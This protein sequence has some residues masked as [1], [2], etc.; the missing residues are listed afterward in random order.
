MHPAEQLAMDGTLSGYDEAAQK[1]AATDTARTHRICGY[2]VSTGS[3]EDN[4]LLI[5]DA[6]R[7]RRGKWVVTLNT[8]MIARGVREPEYAALL[9]D[10]DLIFA[11]GMPIVWASRGHDDRNSIAERTTGV[12]LVQRLFQQQEIPA[13]AIIGGQNPTLTLERFPA[14]RSACKWV[15]SGRVDNSLEQ[16]DQFAATL[17][18]QEVVIVFLAL[19][20]PKQDHLAK[21]LR[22][23]L[24]HCVVIGVGGT[25]EILGPEGSRAPNWMQRGGLEWL[26]RLMNDPARLWRRYLLRYPLGVWTLAT[27][28]Y[29]RGTC[30]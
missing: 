16:A 2:D 21:L 18:E 10:A 1:I 28:Y 19:G 30:K 20:I 15:F 17:R 26:Y 23:R 8:E 27:D 11:D 29:A 7:T 4:L 12:D 25:F 6:A 13:F 9:R 22:A 24:P 3:L 5:S 14:A